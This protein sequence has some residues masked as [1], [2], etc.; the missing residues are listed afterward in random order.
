[1]SSLKFVLFVLAVALVV[2][3]GERSLGSADGEP[4]SAVTD[5]ETFWDCNPGV[6]CGELIQCVDGVC[7]PDLGHIIIPCAVAECATDDDCVVAVPENCCYG[8]PEVVPRSIL[9]SMNC[10]Y[11]AGTIH[12]PLPECTMLCERC[13]ECYP[14]PLGAKCEQGVCTASE[15]GCPP[16]GEE[17]LPTAT[18]EQIAQSPSTY[19]GGRYRV[20]GAVLPG[21]GDCDGGP[22]PFNCDFPPMLNG[23][24]RL[25]GRLCNLSIHSLGSVCSDEFMSESLAPGGW[26]EIEGEVQANPSPW[27]PPYMEV[28]GLRLIEPQD[29]GGGYEVTVTMVVSDADDPTCVPPT[30]AVGDNGR[31][32]VAVNGDN[33]TVIAPMFDCWWEFVGTL[34]SY[35][36]FTAWVP[37]DCDGC[38]CDYS[39]SGEVSGN[40][41]TGEY[42]SFDGTCRHIIQFSGQRSP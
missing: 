9:P 33:L 32:L 2:G 31:V 38:C 22:G 35:W 11:E 8:C 5:C 42:E 15:T 18:T 17:Q 40:H 16:F 20:Q 23:A 29:I 34:D 14:Q 26:Y 37:I 6:E 25:Q 27:E 24:V 36:R 39:V 13:P 10:F 1:M 19:D 3:C 41:L 30:L 4:D 21:A 12:V 28:T 7:R